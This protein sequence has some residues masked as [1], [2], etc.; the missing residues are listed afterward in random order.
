MKISFS[1]AQSTGKSTLLNAM[2]L[3]EKYKDWKFEPEITRTLRD[4][5]GVSINENANALTQYMIMNCHIEN[6]VKHKTGDVIMDRCVLDGLVY[7]TYLSI[8]DPEA[9]PEECVLYAAN[10]FDLLIKEYDIIF[11]L[12]PEFPI[13]DDGVRSANIDFRDKIVALFETAIDHFSVPVVRITGSVE[14]RLA[15][16]DAAITAHRLKT[17]NS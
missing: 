3:D 2:K 1:G 13:V 4:R 9:I 10:V 16:I 8:A 11:Y 5:L 15:Q 12:T 14:E 17:N 7:T 6:V